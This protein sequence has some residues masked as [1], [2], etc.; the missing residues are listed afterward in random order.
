MIFLQADIP[1]SR[2]INYSNTRVRGI[3]FD[4]LYSPFKLLKLGANGTYQ[5]IRR[6]DIAEA[7][8]QY[9]ENSRVPN[10]PFLFGNTHACFQWNN[11]FQKK[12]K[13]EVYGYANYVHRFFLQSVSERQE[14]GLFSQPESFV[15][16][17]IIPND[18]RTGTA[19]YTA[20]LVYGFPKNGVSLG[21]E[22]VNV[23]N[24]KIFD[25]FNVE[26]PGRSF[27]LKLRYQLAGNNK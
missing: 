10:I 14:P 25:N 5:D 15:S 1:F 18:G 4:V 27:H 16:T 21:F 12:S 6:V 20:G 19:L 2:Y 11:L 3:E 23:S 7:N 9:L 8:I 24:T 17:L 22:C 13:V 26:R